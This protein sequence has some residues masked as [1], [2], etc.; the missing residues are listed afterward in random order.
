MKKT[1]LKSLAA[2]TCMA[3][4]MGAMAHNFEVDGIYYL[5]LDEEQLT[6]A[7]TFKG[8]AFDSHDNEYS[9]KVVIPNTVNFNENDYTVTAIYNEAFCQ[10][11]E[12][13]EVVIGE[14]VSIIGN[15]AFMNCLSLNSVTF[16]E[17]VTYIGAQAFVNCSSLTSAELGNNITTLGV[18]AFSGTG[19]TSIEIPQGLTAISEYAFSACTG[20]KEVTIPENITA[21]GGCA[22]ASC[23]GLETVVMS[24]SVSTIGIMAFASCTSLTTVS[25]GSNMAMIDNYAFDYCTAITDISC[26]ATTPPAIQEK[27]FAEEVYE[28][29]TLHVVT[30][31]KDAYA[32]AYCWEAF[33]TITDD[34]SGVNDVKRDNVAIVAINGQLHAQ[35]V[36]ANEQV[37]IY[38]LTGAL[39]HQTTVGC[40]NAI[41]LPGGVYIVQVGN[42]V[43]KVIL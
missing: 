40:L 38:N 25:L 11:T 43:E 22:F 41:T 26:K 2:L 7:V 27:T 39:M 36:N 13:T 30:G 21:I 29:A 35:G 32:T 16:P 42:V 31:C 10:C 37:N 6:A 19:L 24:D 20:L 34:L 23:T 4:S 28:N 9:G 5:V 3:C 12:V 14:N 1:L 33:A 8:N 18:Y 17:S 15:K